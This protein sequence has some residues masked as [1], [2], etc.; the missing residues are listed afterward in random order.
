MPFRSE[1]NI[2]EDLFSSVLSHFKKYHP[3]GNLKFNY[4]GI[5]QRSKLRILMEN[6]PPICL[7]LNFTPN[8]LGGYELNQYVLHFTQRFI[9]TFPSTLLH[10][11][12]LHKFDSKH[13]PLVV[14]PGVS[15]PSKGVVLESRGNRCKELSSSFRILLTVEERSLAVAATTWTARCGASGAKGVAAA[16]KSPRR[17][18]AAVSPAFQ[19]LAAPP[20]PRRPH[21]CIAASGR[22]AG[23]PPPSRSFCFLWNSP[24]MRGV[25]TWT[26]LRSFFA[27]LPKND[28]STADLDPMG[29]NLPTFSRYPAL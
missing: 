26:S 20:C 10:K 19:L 13:S 18:V 28:T 22:P 15:G 14:S 17:A 24:I 21:H 5:F 6:I 3:S 9:L 8:T 11:I 16:L 1:K 12:P 27:V 23:W 29:P 4:L 7:K 2:L 25:V